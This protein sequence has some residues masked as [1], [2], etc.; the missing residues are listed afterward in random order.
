V[1][2]SLGRE[3]LDDRRSILLPNCTGSV[4]VNTVAP[5]HMLLLLLLLLLP[6][7]VRLRQFQAYDNG[8]CRGSLCSRSL[9]SRVKYWTSSMATVNAEEGANAHVIIMCWLLTV[10]ST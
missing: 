5:F 7:R 2:G 9:A 1:Y 10:R 3:L 4:T 6:V 8:V